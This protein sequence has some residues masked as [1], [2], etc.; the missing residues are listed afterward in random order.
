VGTSWMV[1][2]MAVF[3]VPFN[4]ANLISLTL[5][6]GIGVSNGIHILNRFTEERHPTILAKSTGKAVLV[7]AL[8]TIAGFG[9]LMLAKHRGIASLGQVMSLGTATCMLAALTVLPAV[10][11]LLTRSGW[12]L[13]HGW[14]AHRATG[15]EKVPSPE[16]RV[17]LR[18]VDCGLRTFRDG[19][20]EVPLALE[21][22][23]SFR[24][25]LIYG[26]VTCPG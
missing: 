22:M 10:L 6:I 23:H 12:K 14:F 11:I 5:L 19:F 24:V 3:H 8:T 9:S 4:P 2:L 17:R 7:S 25:H 21:G 18:T 20:L 13:A 15:D 1:G 26:G 16:S